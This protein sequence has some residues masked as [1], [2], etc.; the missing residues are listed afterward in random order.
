MVLADTNLDG[1]A[2][3]STVF[4]QD[5]TINTALGICILGNRV[6]VSCSPH[7]FILTDTDGDDRAD[8]RELMF[9]DGSRGDHDH[10]LH[11]FVFGP[12]G[13]LYFNFGNEVRSLFRPKGGHSNCHCTAPFPNTN[14]NRS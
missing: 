11:A 12:D 2:D 7:V 6:I 8:K 14:E 4:Y 3:S 5:N 13:K 10:C 1:Q 9:E